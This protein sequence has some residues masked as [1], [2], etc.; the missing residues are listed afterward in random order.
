M[1]KIKRNNKNNI[2]PE[3]ACELI[4]NNN[5]DSLVILDVRTPKEYN[6]SHIENSINIDYK[7]KNF[8]EEVE[9]LDK[10]NRYIVY[11]HS[12]RRSSDAIKLM[13]KSGFIDLKN[14]S[15]GIRAWKK[16]KCPIV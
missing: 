9:K 1:F 15:G 14:I 12:G 7:S 5:E 2:K 8:K 6:E 16:N 13:E 3:E 10:N 4:N 11:C